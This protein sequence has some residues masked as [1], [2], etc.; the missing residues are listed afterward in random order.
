MVDIYRRLYTKSY[1]CVSWWMYVAWPCIV[2]GRIPMLQV[3][4]VGK[5]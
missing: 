2:L 4:E 1:F 5:Q 3:M